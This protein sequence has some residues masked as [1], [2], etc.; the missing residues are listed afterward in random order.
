MI[1]YCFEIKY[2]SSFFILIEVKKT[3]YALGF[4]AQLPPAV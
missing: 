2:K 4:A 3:R 1:V